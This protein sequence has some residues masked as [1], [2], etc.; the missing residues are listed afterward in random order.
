MKF[1]AKLTNVSLFIKTSQILENNTKEIILKLNKKKI[2][3]I[4]P[5][6]NLGK[7]KITIGTII[8]SGIKTSSIFDDFKIES[9]HNDEIFLKIST[10]NLSKALNIAQKSETSQLKLTKS[11]GIPSLTLIT[12]DSE[13]SSFTQDIPIELL[14][15]EEI[16][17]MGT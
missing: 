3:L 7:K 13:F 11:D 10:E 15:E 16:N 17:E 4:Q 1:K 8:W 6:Q 12:N 9:Q 14:T 2:L 5:S